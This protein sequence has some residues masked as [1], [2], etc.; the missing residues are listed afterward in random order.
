MCYIYLSVNHHV[1][2]QKCSKLAVD[3]FRFQNYLKDGI[4]SVA[5]NG[6]VSDTTKA[7]YSVPQGSKLGPVLFSTYKND[8]SQHNY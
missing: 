3:S 4:E 2:L 1:V 5:V 8:M 6:E 7:D